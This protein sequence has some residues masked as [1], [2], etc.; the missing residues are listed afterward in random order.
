MI[1]LVLFRLAMWLALLVLV[2][3]CEVVEVWKR[4]ARGD[5]YLG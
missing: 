5:S 4:R 3:A 2:T 1:W